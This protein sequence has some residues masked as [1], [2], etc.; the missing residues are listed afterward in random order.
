M[1]GEAASKLTKQ[2]RDQCPEIPWSSIV[3]MRNRLIHV[4]YDVDLDR[5][6]DTI[7]DDPPPL[8][9]ALEKILPPEGKS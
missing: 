5:V 2:S 6:W 8:I 4:Y 9:T 3:A 1:I 7:T